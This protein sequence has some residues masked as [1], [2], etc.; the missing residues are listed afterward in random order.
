MKSPVFLKS[1]FAILLSGIVLGNVSAQR[2]A[3]STTSQEPTPMPAKVIGRVSDGRVYP[4]KLRTSNKNP[5][6][7]H[8]FKIRWSKV[9]YKNGQKFIINRVEPPAP[10]K[11][12][13]LV[14]N[15]ACKA[16]DE[17]AL[18][19]AWKQAA[20]KDGGSFMVFATI[21]DHR[22]TRVRWNSQ[23]EEFQAWSN[24]DFN[25]LNGFASFEGR[26]KNYTM[27]LL[28]SNASLADLKQVQSQRAA[29][30]AL[31]L[32]DFSKLDARGASPSYMIVKGDE[33]NDSAMEFIEALHDLYAAE[34]PRL[35]AAYHARIKNAKINALHQEHLRLNP[36]PKS[37]VIINFWKRDVQ[38]E[39]AEAEVKQRNLSEGRAK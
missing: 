29:Q 11:K 39:R 25:H 22:Y 19:A 27:M 35:V 2:Q 33:K 36:P 4:T 20:E 5:N 15:P 28:T 24:I 17:A 3:T 9:Q 38:K 6:M 21:Y 32:P 7:Q 12:P 34:K 31:Q 8:A 13:V 26:G 18:L 30:E 14:K 23:G 1:V 16:T 10:S 37:D